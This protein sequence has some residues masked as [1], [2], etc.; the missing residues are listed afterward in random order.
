MRMGCLYTICISEHINGLKDL[1]KKPTNS[2]HFIYEL[3]GFFIWLS[4][5]YLMNI[6]I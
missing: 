6:P 1:I 2:Y 4:L 3:V 5:Y